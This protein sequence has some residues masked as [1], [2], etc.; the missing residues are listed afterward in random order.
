MFIGTV[1]LAREG[2]FIFEFWIFEILIIF[3]FYN[4]FIFYFL[5][6][7]LFYNY[8]YSLFNIYKFYKIK[9]LKNIIELSFEISSQNR[10]KL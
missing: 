4:I 5:E 2:T 6:Y 10:L 7:F 1:L 9:I 8:L 3:Y